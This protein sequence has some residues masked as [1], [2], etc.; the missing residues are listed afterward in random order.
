MS[1][2]SPTDVGEARSA[3]EVRATREGSRERKLTNKGFEWQVSLYSQKFRSAVA[4]WRKRASGLEVLLSDTTDISAFKSERRALEHDMTE[5]TDI[6]D[7]L[8]DLLRPE[9]K[10]SDI[11]ERY[12][13]IASENY[14]LIKKA[15]NRISEIE[16][17]RNEIGSHVSFNSG[18][19]HHVLVKISR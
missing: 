2:S 18:P 3:D 14:Q 13:A 11:C 1:D 19:S 9:S 17:A 16:A 15:A 10:E 12:E 6:F 8:E 5:L 4:V 7:H